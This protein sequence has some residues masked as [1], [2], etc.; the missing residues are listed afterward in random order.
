V[1]GPQPDDRVSTHQLLAGVVAG[2]NIVQIGQVHGD[3]HFHGVREVYRLNPWPRPA[4]V[5]GARARPSRLL[6]AR[7]A[8]VPFDAGRRR[9][10]L[11]RLTAWRDESASSRTSVLLVH[12][13]GG[14]G[15]TRLAGYFADQSRQAGWRV[16]A[17]EQGLPRSVGP[18]P[19]AGQP[20]NVATQAIPGVLVVLDYAER[21]PAQDLLVLM[22]DLLAMPVAVRLLLL[23]RPAGPWWQGL[24]HELSKRDVTAGAVRLPA[25]AGAQ[26]DRR[27]VFT[28]ARDAFAAAL[29]V[30]NPETINAPAAL[31]DD[32]FDLVLTVHM[33]ALVAVH[34]RHLRRDD[35][36][37]R[38][39]VD[40]DPVALAEYLLD[41]ERS[42][43]QEVHR[44]RVVATD[45]DTM[46]R[47]TY[48]ATLTR[49]LPR[50]DGVAVLCRTNAV[51]A[52]DLAARV[53]DDHARCYPP[54][55][56][57]TVLEPLY[58]DRLGEDFLALQT[59]LLPDTHTAAL[60]PA[61]DPWTMHERGYQSDPWA[62]DALTRLL[63]SG[64]QPNQV[65][66]TMTILIETARRWPHMARQRLYPLLL[67]NAKLMAAAGSAALTAL[68]G[69]D[70][71][72]PDGD[73]TIFM[74]LEAVAA[75]LPRHPHV[76]LDVGTAAL[77]KRLVDHK[78]AVT[79]DPDM[80]AWMYEELSR[81][82][83]NAGHFREAVTAA[84]HAV[85]ILRQLVPAD[86]ALLPRLA[87]RL[88]DLGI[89]L[90]KVGRRQEALT[91]SEESAAVLRRLA[92][93][94]PAHVA[95]FAAALTGLGSRLSE[96]DRI[97]DAIA[98]TEE[99]VRL[100][101]QLVQ[102]DPAKHL[103]DLAGALSNLGTH[104]G[105][106]RS[107]TQALAITQ[108]AVGYWR[109]LAE[110][111][112]A[113]HLDGLAIALANL[114]VRLSEL[115]RLDDAIT[116][117]REATGHYHRLVQANP[118]AYLAELA[119]TLDSLSHRLWDVGR[120][121]EALGPLEEA[122]E[123][124]RQLATAIP[125]H[126]PRLASLVH[127]LGGRLMMLDRDHDAL[128]FAVEAVTIRQ[129]LAEAD[130][131]HHGRL[132]DSLTNLGSAL[133]G[134]TGRDDLL[135]ARARKLHR[136]L[137]GPQPPRPGRVLTLNGESY[138]LRED[139]ESFSRDAST[140][141][142]ALLKVPIND[143]LSDNLLRL[144]EVL[145]ATFGSD[146]PQ[147]EAIRDTALHCLNCFADYPTQHIR[148][149]DQMR[150]GI[151]RG[152]VAAESTGRLREILHMSACL[153]CGSHDAVWI[154][155]PN[156]R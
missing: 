64:S 143:P 140:G 46:A 39:G 142:I 19:S 34:E 41:R 87:A 91:A 45:P 137:T 52:P 133:Q 66:S 8:V 123:L 54:G 131:A 56:A 117:I 152:P 53:L 27:A 67:S 15:K 35:T 118:A 38:P 99:A 155:D 113:A 57:A 128:V 80:R 114:G 2:R 14:Q 70:D 93:V 112:P 60:Y 138:P 78:L 115:G 11:D 28:A 101:Q 96:L 104:V 85:A 42:Y 98:P 55:T 153:D 150:Q 50:D 73:T 9:E 13:P 10:Q 119:T 62:H 90:S 107:R 148:L 147:I 5:T 97:A 109:R 23:V 12:G 6:A 68:S 82:H 81:R 43:W 134:L 26:T 144:Y 31:D 7:H 36:D 59:P 127:N 116:H 61:A 132:A 135:T 29:D 71:P 16:V 84:E 18:L 154:Y 125:A 120:R 44:T 30:P 105:Q 110:A 4:A 124:Y 58:P 75:V 106:V 1:S 63:G 20:E 47:A 25:L 145:S 40:A 65:R 92:G 122:V 77:T 37:T 136:E 100:Y 51:Y 149:R 141:R 3:V 130:P 17:A 69:L 103:P 83:G 22:E 156:R 32:R 33:A 95:D 151:T 86:P 94:D 108:E 88:T 74:V 49:P 89:H 24:A 48:V 146:A 129:Q 79:T 76:D 21:W 102:A 111:D 139:F 121:E 126:L 72:P